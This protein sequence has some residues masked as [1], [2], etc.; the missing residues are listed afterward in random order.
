M[1]IGIVGCAGR[2][3][4]RLVA[5]ASETSGCHLTGGTVRSGSEASGRDIGELAG[6]GR[7]GVAAGESAA[8]LFR[9]ADVVIDFTTP[10]AAEENADLAATHATALVVGTTGLAESQKTALAEAGRKVPV[11]YAPNMSLGVNLLS[12]LVERV[13]EALD[14]DFDIEVL[15]MHHRHKVD[16]PSGTALALGEAA[17]R[18]RGIDLEQHAQRVRDGVTGP[19]KRGDIGFATLRGGD[20]VG[21]HSVVFATT[22]ERLELAHKS[23]DRDIFARGALK[24]ALWTKGKGAGFYSMRDVLGL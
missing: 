10:A 7:L 11:V 20:V 23:S 17:A 22:G 12:L 18:G 5:I 8:D 4:K 15:E 14:E 9:H 6:V 13:A 21:E 3:G 16:A 19:R 1:G 2:M 24:A